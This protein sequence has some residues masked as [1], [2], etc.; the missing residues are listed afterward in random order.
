MTGIIEESFGILASDRETI[1]VHRWLPEVP[2]K[3]VVVIS[4]G[5][6]EYALR[7]RA[8]GNALASKGYA[9]Y[10]NDHRGHGYA[11][12]ASR[13]HGDFGQN[14]FQNLVDDL[15]QVVELGA[16]THPNLPVFLLG[17]SMGSYVAQFFVLDHWDILSGVALC[18]GSALDQRPSYDD[19]IHLFAIDNNAS[20]EAART[21]FDW[22]SRDFAIVDSYVDDPLCG[23]VAT[24]DSLRSLYSIAP[25]LQNS[26]EI[27]KIERGFP[28]LMFTGECDPINGFLSHFKVLRDRYRQAGLQNITTHIY[29][30]ARHEVLNETNRSEVLCDIDNWLTRVI[31]DCPKREAIVAIGLDGY[32]NKEASRTSILR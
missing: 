23:F 32:R 27:Q 12:K 30:G 19:G 2:A 21:S 9:V 31:Q 5:M 16:T 29:P 4:H 28:I 15:R 3:A 6:G 26:F 25:R 8:T 18:G 24:P 20:F 11:I 13:M 17:H 1:P 22:L 7:Y 14:G 10:S